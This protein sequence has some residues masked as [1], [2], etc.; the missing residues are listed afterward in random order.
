MRGRLRALTSVPTWLLHQSGASPYKL[1]RSG[2]ILYFTRVT[3]SLPSSAAVDRLPCPTRAS[4][5]SLGQALQGRSTEIEELR[6]LPDDIVEAV[7]DLGIFRSF[8]PECYGGHQQELN[9][10]LAV[11]E[12]LGYW[13]GAVGWCAMI[14]ATTALQSAYLPEEH[15]RV[16][17]A[18]NLRVVT[19][20]TAEPRGTARAVDGGVVAN[21]RWSWGSGAHHCDWIGA[22]CRLEAEDPEARPRILFAFF[23][24]AQVI[25]HDTWHVGGLRG[26]GSGDFEVR[27]AFVPEGRWVER[28]V[29]PARID[30]PLYKFPH[31]GLLALGVASVGLGMARRS[32]AELREIAEG[33]HYV[34]SRRT[35]AQR[36]GVQARFAEAEAR[37]LA[38]REYI[39]ASVAR[40][41]Q[42]AQ[43]GDLEVEHRRQLRLSATYGMRS[44]VRVVDAMY[45]LAGGTAV[46]E[47]NPLERLFRDVHVAASHGMVAERTYELTGRIALGLETD[48]TQL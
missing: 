35:L 48:V 29:D 32:L 6:R 28:Y 44:A 26:T 27:D 19:G 41:W 39:D 7:I 9:E 30:H 37:L 33:K 2:A 40:G 42:A 3:D 23:E 17:Y 4:A 34:G 46:F 10:G 18:D 8:V 16:I 31:L 20:G 36:P 12:E 45:E 47:S 43:G 13:D 14:G 11:L 25:L 1:Y 21:G 15:A 24:K 22:G 5:R 38:A